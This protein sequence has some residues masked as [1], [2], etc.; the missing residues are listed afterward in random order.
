M[1]AIFDRVVREIFSKYNHTFLEKMAVQDG[2][3]Q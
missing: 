2:I 3:W 1:D